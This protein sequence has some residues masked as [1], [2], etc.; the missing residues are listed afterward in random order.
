MQAVRAVVLRQLVL[1]AIQRKSGLGDAVGVAADQ[2]AEKGVVTEVIVE[3]VETQD[4]VR[5]FAVPVG[6]EKGNHPAAV[7]RDADFDTVAVR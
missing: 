1:H 3:V 7:I 6:R 4:D 5:H 2:S